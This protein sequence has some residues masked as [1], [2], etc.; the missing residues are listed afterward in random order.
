MDKEI[1]LSAW[2]NR[3]LLKERQT[4]NAIN[5]TM[6]LLNR[7]EIRVAEKHDDEW[8]INE[9]VKKAIILY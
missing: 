9:W 5:D 1:I 7:G 4:I 3:E 6:A 8:I 2:E